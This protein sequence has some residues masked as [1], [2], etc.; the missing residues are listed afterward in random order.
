MAVWLAG[1][2]NRGPMAWGGARHSN[3]ER[4]GSR[5]DHR[6]RDRT[7]ELKACSEVTACVAG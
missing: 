4:F 1:A 6:V 2:E 3:P 7:E 5:A